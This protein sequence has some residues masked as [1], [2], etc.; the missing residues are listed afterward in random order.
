MIAGRITKL[1]E[2][3][4]GVLIPNSAGCYATVLGAS[5]ASVTPVLINY[6]TGVIQNC[7]YAQKSCG[8]KTIITSKKLLEKLEVD[9]IDGMIF[10]ED[11]VATLTILEKVS[12]LLKF[13][14]PTPVDDGDLSEETAIILFTS[15]SEKDP[16]GVELSH[17]NLISNLVSINERFGF[18]HKEVFV[19]VLPTFHVFG[20]T[21][22]MW[23]PLT[24]GCSIV[25]HPSP[26]EYE[27][28]VRSVRKYKGNVLTATPTFFH[29]YL[30]KSKEGDFASLRYPIAGGDKLSNKIREGFLS[31]HGINIYEGYGTTETSPVISSNA[32]QY[33]RPGSIGKPLKGVQIK[34]V[35]KETG[36]DVEVNELGKILVKGD[37][38]MKGYLNDA[39]ATAR[40]IKDGWYDTGDMGTIDQN[41]YLW[42][43][44]RLRRFAKIGG[45]MVSLVAIESEL[46]KL[47]PE[48][49]LC[50]VVDTPHPSRGSQIIAAI[51]TELDQ[52]ALLN[53]LKENLP[54]ISIPKK[55]VFMESMPV[56]GN[57]KVDFKQ[58]TGIVQQQMSQQ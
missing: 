58:V 33:N 50:C 27:K 46:E 30:R 11:W 9:P 35:D 26:L 28:I 54:P 41:G 13:L 23:L 5:I 39:E 36:Q 3:R 32:P 18:T 17:K 29:G 10:I 25:V 56:M 34:I 45:E 1:K 44:G 37:L 48:G 40:C 12:G 55:I 16:K 7:L 4:V 19:S 8:F 51:T 49:T 22:T 15:G 31:K 43:K 52:T 53:K 57:G 42:H 14:L 20:L 21:T 47:L 6:S 38:V 2:S 24:L